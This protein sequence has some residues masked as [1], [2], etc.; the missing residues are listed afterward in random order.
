MLY[1]FPSYDISI[2]AKD[3]VEAEKK[4]NT[5]LKKNHVHDKKDLRVNSEN[6]QLND[7]M[8]R[9]KKRG[10]VWFHVHTK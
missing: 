3:I 5:L 2:D 1:R 7:K 4:L 10:D 8:I 9:W 6:V